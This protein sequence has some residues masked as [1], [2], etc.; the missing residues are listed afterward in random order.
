MLRT[1]RALRHLGLWNNGIGCGGADALERGLRENT[2]LTQLTLAHNDL[3]TA[4]EITDKI[5]E[6]ITRNAEARKLTGM[7]LSSLERDEL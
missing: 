5:E 6:A 4:T 3:E 1:N 7:E 2:V